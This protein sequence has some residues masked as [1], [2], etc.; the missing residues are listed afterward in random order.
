[1]ADFWDQS[2][3]FTNPQ[4]A[5][6]EQLAQQRRY[7]EELQKRSGGEVNRPAG[8][9]ANMIDALTAGLTRNNANQIQ[10]QAAQGNAAD[11]ARLAAQ[12]QAGQFPDPQ[13]QGHLAANPMASPEMRGFVGQLTTPQAITSGLNQPGYTS[14][15]A[16]VT[17]PPI[18]GQYQPATPMSQATQGNSISGMNPTPNVQ[19]AP[20]T[21]TNPQGG[22]YGGLNFRPATPAPPPGSG[23]PAAGAGLPP[24]PPPVGPNGAPAG[25]P[26]MD[27]LLNYGIKAT[28]LQEQGKAK[29][30]TMTAD[31]AAANAAP[32]LKNIVT[33]MLDDIQ[34]HG[35]DWTMGPSA[36]ISLQAKRLAAN[37]APGLMKDQLDKIASAESFSKMSA[38]LAGATPGV[39]GSTDAQ[40]VNRIESN[41]GLHNTVGGAAGLLKL[42]LQ[43]LDQQQALGQ[44]AASAKTPDEYQKLRDKF[45]NDNPLT[46]PI[47]N[48]PLRIDMAASQARSGGPKLISVEP[49]K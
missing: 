40:L 24:V 20:L 49:I 12:L 21:P 13:T 23:G 42:R 34:T 41:P 8:A 31:L 44:I 19:T 46:N 11:I 27:Q 16:G 22:M 43:M 2:P 10:S 33:T 3:N 14:P 6:P 37:Y 39:N 9:L 32:P 30:G 45:F 35:K 28:F 5:S 15:N 26:Q 17:A 4:Y 7:A 29:T 38:T 1:M 18:R 48:H 47:T 25:F 36:E